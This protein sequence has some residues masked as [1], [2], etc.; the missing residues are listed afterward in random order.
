[1]SESE[2]IEPRSDRATQVADYWSH[3][4]TSAHF[5]RDLYWRSVPEVERYFT[6][7]A[8]GGDDRYPTWTDYCLD[9]LAGRTPVE[10]MLS[11][12]CGNG[13]LERFLARAGAFRECDAWDI[14]PG[15]IATAR[16]LARKEG[17]P[18]IFYEVRDANTAEMPPERY[19]AVWFNHSLH[20]V[21]ALETVLAGI[22]RSLKP[23]GLLFLNEYVGANAFDFPPRQRE[24]L[25]AAFDLIPR[26]FRRHRQSG[27]VAERLGLPTAAEVAAAD[28]SES[29]RSSEILDV[30]RDTFD[31][32]ACNPAAGTLLQFLLNGIAGNFRSDDPESIRVLDMLLAI[33]S[34][35]IDVGDL[36]SDFVVLVARRREPPPPPRP[37]RPAPPA[38][39]PDTLSRTAE[40]N[41]LHN[42]VEVLRATVREIESSR[43]WRIV[44]LYYSA[45]RR[46]SRWLGRA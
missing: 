32:I 34:T 43:A 14:A 44:Q 38:L 31:V 23:G 3:A 26:R 12:G 28:P 13:D 22:S 27:A 1:M 42:E 30:V 17:H 21:E 41:R 4:L 10:R 33:E 39:P 7:R 25:L 29:V 35:L 37:R 19:D 18:H 9:F 40:E 6:L 36:T 15:A 2:P 5:S 8:S 45:H 20:H 46:L 24:V 11:V 16:R